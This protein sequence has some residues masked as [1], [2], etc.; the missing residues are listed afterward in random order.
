MAAAGAAS[1]S[2]EGSAG[3]AAGSAGGARGAVSSSRTGG[4]AGAGGVEATERKKRVV[5]LLEKNRLP[6]REV[7]EGKLE[8]LGGVLSIAAPYTDK[9]CFSTNSTVLTRVAALLSAAN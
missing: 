9:S 6:V 8:V 2:A 3:G 7:E 4:G 1:S 5:A